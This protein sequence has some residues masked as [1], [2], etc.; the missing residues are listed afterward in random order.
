MKRCRHRKPTPLDNQ[1]SAILLPKQPI[2]VPLTGLDSIKDRLGQ[3]LA[4]GA[5]PRRI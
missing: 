5:H 4:G 1:K 2:L 3:A